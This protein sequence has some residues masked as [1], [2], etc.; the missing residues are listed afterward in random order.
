MS[1]TSNRFSA[2]IAA[3]LIAA[4]AACSRNS[5]APTDGGVDSLTATIDGQ[6]FT[7]TVMAAN[8]LTVNGAQSLSIVGFNGCQGDTSL[9]VNLRPAAVGT[10]VAGQ[11]G[12]TASGG[13]N[14]MAGGQSIGVW[15]STGGSITISMLSST[16]V[17]GI[18]TFPVLTPL[19]S[20]TAGN[21]SVAN[22]SFNIQIA[23][24][25]LC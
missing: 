24:R 23:E 3:G 13:L 21:R 19:G 7:A 6:P 1:T 9:D 8:V 12:I 20:G 5:T 14:R 16:R 10:H 22:G 17:A 25:K 11:S 15:Q 4:T 18:F 2:V